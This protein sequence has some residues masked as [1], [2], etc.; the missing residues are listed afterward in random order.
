MLMSP[1]ASFCT[2]IPYPDYTLI[3]QAQNPNSY[4]DPKS[5]KSEKS[6]VDPAAVVRGAVVFTE[7]FVDV[8][9]DFDGEICKSLKSISDVAAPSSDVSLRA[10]R[11]EGAVSMNTGKAFDVVFAFDE[12]LLVES[13]GMAARVPAK[14]LLGAL[15]VARFETG[16]HEP[17][18][19]VDGMAG[20]AAGGP[21]PK[22]ASKSAH[23]SSC[24]G[25][26]VA[27]TGSLPV[28]PL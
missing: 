6:G 21:A 15:L 18:V 3:A 25:A 27:E 20:A 2:L 28:W 23:P 11:A 13:P 16:G 10:V 26:A 5:I 14:G 24:C 17:V 1:L 9:F 8:D 7:S 4:P 22:A 12:S 19:L